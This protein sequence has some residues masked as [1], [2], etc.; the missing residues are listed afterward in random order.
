MRVE[1]NGETR[2]VEAAT[3]A[4][5]LAELGYGEGPVATAVNH[6][7]VRARDREETPLR[8]GD[9]VEIVSPRQGG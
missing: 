4:R 7:F 6:E 1:V 2:D 9:A 5:L 8:D 3:L